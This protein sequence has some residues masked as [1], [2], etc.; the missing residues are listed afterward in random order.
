[1]PA[2][3]DIASLITGASY[4]AVVP[5]TS[6][7]STL[8]QAELTN[9]AF[10]L[11]ERI[12]FVR[13]FSVL[14]SALPEK[15]S[16]IRDDFLGVFHDTS[17]SLLYADL[18]WKTA[19]GTGTPV[20]S[21]AS[22]TAKN[23]GNAVITLPA[24]ATAD[25]LSVFLGAATAPMM[26]FVGFDSLTVVFKAIDNPGNVSTQFQFG[27]CQSATNLAVGAG[28]TDSVRVRYSKFDSANWLIHTR[29]ASVSAAPVD[30]GVPFVSGEYIVAK[31]QHN[32][33]AGLDVSLNGAL[34]TTIAAAD[35]P[36]GSATLGF[37]AFKSAADTFACS[38]QMDEVV[39]LQTLTTRSGS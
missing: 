24:G 20:A 1:M 25:Q 13:K 21:F 9:T 30:S 27:L 16:L 15:F 37:E 32:A 8:T 2:P 39:G 14:A 36:T 11:G 35:V 6:D 5:V 3:V 28:G 26:T 18:I 31:W 23:P 22:G 33:A 17:N 12:E 29:K 4:P 7:T 19:V 34:I 38:L 10:A